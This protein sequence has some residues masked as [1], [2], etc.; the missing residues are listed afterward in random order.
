MDKRALRVA[1][2]Y[3]S[4]KVPETTEPNEMAE[5]KAPKDMPKVIS[6][7]D[8]LLAI[9]D[10][11]KSYYQ[12]L[13]LVPLKQLDVPNLFIV[14]D[15]MVKRFNDSGVPEKEFEEAF[16]N[17]KPRLLRTVQDLV[18]SDKK[19]IKEKMYS[20]FKLNPPKTEDE[21]D[22]YVRSFL[23]SLRTEMISRKKKLENMQ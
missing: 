4:A 5:P 19:S 13:I 12:S 2:Q 10:A 15:K 3:I 18:F 11:L 6:E 23:M 20:H 8:I 7:R 1:L 16:Q 17:V 21:V 14:F 9:D 22:S